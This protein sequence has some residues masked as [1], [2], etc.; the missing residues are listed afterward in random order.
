GVVLRKLTDEERE[1]RAKALESATVREAE[2]RRIAEDEARR[3]SERDTV[4][5]GE[6][7]KAEARKKEEEDRRRHDDEAKRKAEQEAKKRFGEEESK[8]RAAPA[9]G[10]PG[11]PQI[12]LRNV[13]Q[14]PDEEEAPRPRRGGAAGPARPAPAP[15]PSRGGAQKNRGRLTVVTA[16][17]AGEVRERSVASFRRRVQRLK[18]V[19]NNESKRKPAREGP[20]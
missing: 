19:N 18:G 11:T 12:N 2:E 6:R 14:E 8:T 10:K 4:E 15:R 9:R 17:D 3:R 13:K 7:E 5:R 20:H 1:A 16:L